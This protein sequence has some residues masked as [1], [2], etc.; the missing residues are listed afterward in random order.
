[1]SEN[2][3]AE[4]IAESILERD[5]FSRWLGLEPLE[6][7]PGRLVARMKVRAEM[8]NAFGTCHGGV[9]F[10]FADSALAF[11]ANSRG[12]ISLL[13]EANMSFPAKVLEGDVLTVKAEEASLG[14]KVAVYNIT[15]SKQDES[16]VGIF[17]GTVYRTRR[18]YELGPR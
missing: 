3:T 5:A 2:H 6:I 14:E 10:A 12:R 4:E 11:A 13:L 17:R 16:V 8:I 15:V 9:T 1:M 7:G 18:P